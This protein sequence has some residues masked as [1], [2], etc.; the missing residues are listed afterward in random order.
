MLIWY[1]VITVYL[2]LHTAHCKDE[3][4]LYGLHLKEVQSLS[5]VRSY[6][7]SACFCCCS[8][9][10]LGLPLRPHRLQ[11]ARLSCPSPPPRVCSNSCP[12]SQRHHPTI[13][14]SVI[15]FSSGLQLA[16][17]ILMNGCSL[18]QR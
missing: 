14:S 13:S 1:K 15:P 4:F 3:H 16:R 8:V 17:S 9:A 2:L 18:H 6:I 5:Q 10:Q 12:L 7:M 11:H